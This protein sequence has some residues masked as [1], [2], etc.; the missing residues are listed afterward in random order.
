[1]LSLSLRIAIKALGRHKLRTALTMLGM[2]IGVAAVITIVALGT[3]AQQTVSSDIQSAGT[4]LINVR[5]GNYTR[6]GEESNIAS[7]LG[8]AKTLTIGDE[9]AIAK[10]D[11]LHAATPIVRMR[12]WVAAGAGSRDFTSVMGTSETYPAVFGERMMKGRFLRASDVKGASSVAVL[13]PNLRDR[14]FGDANPVGESIQIHNE[15]FKVVGV[16]DTSDDDQAE[17]VY[18]PYPVL[19]KVLDT[20]SLHQITVAAVRAGDTTEISQKIRDLLRERHRLNSAELAARMRSTGLGGDQMPR[21]GSGVA[22]DFTVKT[23]AAEALTKGLY[24]SVAAFILANMPKVDQVNMQEMAG[25][26][27]RAGSTMTALLIAIATISLVVGGIGIMNIMLV[28]VTERTREIGIRRAVGA[29]AKHVLM[30]FLVEAVA[31]GLCGGGAGIILGFLASWAVSALLDW[32]TSVLSTP[33]CWRWGSPRRW[34]CF[35]V[36]IRRSALPASIQSR[37]C[38]MNK[39]RLFLCAALLATPA[40]AQFNGATAPEHGGISFPSGLLDAE[41]V[42]PKSGGPFQVFFRAPNGEELPA[43]AAAGV[44]LA[45]NHGAVPAEKIALSIDES[46]EAWQGKSAGAQ[47]ISG[48]HLLWNFRGAAVDTEVPFTGVCHAEMDNAPHAAKAGAP[49]ELGFYIRDFLGRPVKTLQIEH[50][51]PMH[52]I[53]V[54]RDL[55]DFWHIHPQLSPS[56][57]FRVAHTFPSGGHYRLYLDYT[58]VSGPNRVDQFDLDVA[59]PAKPAVRLAPGR[60]E[61]VMDGIKMV[62]TTSKPLRAMEDIGFNMAVTDAAS[63]APITNLQPYLGAWAHIAIISEDTERLPPRASDRRAGELSAR[64]EAGPANTLHYPHRYGLPSSRSLQNVGAGA[65]E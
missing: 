19:Q 14:L 40:L 53:V 7:G 6:G 45:I 52:L 32:P 25:T 22:D 28:S 63:G 58:L 55:A 42:L 4:T 51:K 33:F 10:L 64:G 30:Q 61:A 50:E 48:A 34:A 16:L 60:N 12:G 17:S 41:V 8:A 9:E 43:S 18:I 21:G 38:A 5:S 62:L 39:T 24:T 29:R 59:G 46:G 26:L 65:A 1:M 44:T 3:G 2:M 20:T 11:G 47:P 15:N 54:S 31:L 57:L 49:E 23:Q 27:S 37:L 13:G 35:S 56:G 36:S